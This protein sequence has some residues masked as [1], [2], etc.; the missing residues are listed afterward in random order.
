MLATVK[1]RPEIVEINTIKANGIAYYV[2][3]YD[4]FVYLSEGAG[5][6][7]IWKQLI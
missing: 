4:G 7:S 5:G 6:F 1:N 3:V 2:S